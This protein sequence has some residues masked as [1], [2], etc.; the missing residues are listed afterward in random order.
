M[1]RIYSRNSVFTSAAY[2]SALTVFA[3]FDVA[4]SDVSD[5]CDFLSDGDESAGLSAED[6]E[7]GEGEE[8]D[9]RA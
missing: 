5:V 9:L 6:S 2:A 8:E 4:V 1:I 7:A 3:D